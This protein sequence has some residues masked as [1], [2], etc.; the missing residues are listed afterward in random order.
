MYKPV[1]QY[2]VE[3]AVESGIEEIIFVIS[4]DKEQIREHFSPNPELEALLEKKFGDEYLR[5]KASVRR[6]I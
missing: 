5:Y 4:K 6:W 2:L 1:L 3:E